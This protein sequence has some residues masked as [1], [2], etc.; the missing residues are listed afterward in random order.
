MTLN[1]YGRAHYRTLFRDRFVKS[2]EKNQ[3]VTSHLGSVVSW[4][5]YIQFMKLHLFMLYGI[6]DKILRGI[7]LTP[8]PPKPAC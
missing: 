7:L 1:P 8:P 4:L 3:G 2:A 6:K 5:Q